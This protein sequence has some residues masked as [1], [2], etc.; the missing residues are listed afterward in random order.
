VELPIMT[1]IVA[2]TLNPTINYLLYKLAS[3]LYIIDYYLR[4]IVWDNLLTI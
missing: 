1:S 4:V 3:W 2:Y